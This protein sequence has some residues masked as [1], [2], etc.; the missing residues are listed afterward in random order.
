MKK[1]LTLILAFCIIFS[2]GA[3]AADGER[4]TVYVGG[5]KIQPDVTAKIVNS[6]TML[7]LRAVFEAIGAKVSYEEETETVTAE[8]DGTVVKLVIGSDIMTVNGEEKKL[9]VVAY[10]ENDRTMVPVRACSEAFNLQ[11]DWFDDINTVRVRQT[12][13]VIKTVVDST[14]GMAT[15]Q[16]DENGN[17]TYLE[18]LNGY[19][20]KSVYDENECLVSWEDVNDEYTINTYNEF[21]DLIREEVKGENGIVLTYLYEYDENGNNT[22]LTIEGYDQY[23]TKYEYDE[24]NNMT[25]MEMYDGTWEKYTYDSANNLVYAEDSDGVWI[26]YTYDE[27]GNN[28]YVENSDGQWIKWTYDEKGNMTYE[29]ESSGAWLTFSYDENG[30]KISAESDDMFYTYEPVIK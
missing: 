24:K 28:T 5:E 27:N 29:E 7:P 15:W 20:K 19:W 4:V 14:G 12:V 26:K 30:N 23:W 9:D 6:R 2:F 3:L 1:A 25:Y 22:Y 10:T 8:K 17:E 13:S 11:V 21:G 16:Y 18:N